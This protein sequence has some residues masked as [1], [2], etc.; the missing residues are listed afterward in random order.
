[1]FRHKEY[2]PTKQMRETPTTC[3]GVSMVLC[4]CFAF[5]TTLCH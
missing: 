4:A 5:T 2:S 1:M 3:T